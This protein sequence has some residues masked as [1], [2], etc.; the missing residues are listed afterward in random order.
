MMALLLVPLT[1]LLLALLLAGRVTR[2]W[3]LRLA[4]WAALPA[5][6]PVLAAPVEPHFLSWLLL[7]TQIGLDDLS[8][9]FLLFTG[10]V[11]TA[12][13]VSARSYIAR[14]AQVR[15]FTFHLLTLAGNLGLLIA[16]DA[17]TFYLGF[18]LMTFAAY[19]MIVHDGTPAARRAGRVYIIM[20]VMGESALL[21][22]LVMASGAADGALALD[23]ITAAVA[24]SPRRSMI[25]ALLIAGFAV[26]AGALPLHLWLPLAHPVAPTPASAVLSGCMIKAGLLGWL[27]FLPMGEAA[28]PGWGAMLVA[29]GL[30]ATFLGVIAGVAQDDAKTTLAYSSIS[31]MGFMSVA[32]GIGLSTPAAA[33]AAFVACAIY[34]AHHGLAKGALFLGVGVFRA[35]GPARAR[36]AVHAAMLLPALALAGAP[37]TSGVI[38]KS[39][40][41]E[42]AYFATPLPV[43]LS[44]LMTLAAA[45]TAL[46]LIRFLVLVGRGTTTEQDTT[47]PAGLWIPFAALVA[48]TGLFGIA[49]PGP[50]AASDLPHD[51]FSPANLLAATGPLLGGILVAWLGMQLRP[52]VRIPPG[53]LLIPLETLSGWMRGRLALRRL[54]KPAQPITPF[55]ARWYGIYAASSPTDRMLRLEIAV[56]RWEMAALFLIVIVATLFTVVWAGAT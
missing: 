13:G 29:T 15:Y 5:L 42:L 20:A 53:D 2:S 32:V 25:V 22:G 21:A 52:R 27:R 18:A 6:A 3:A 23:E 33:P 10:L 1:P 8:R 17:V 16:L 39:H 36:R 47:P 54:P 55:A 4:P 48:V 7:G 28:L 41:K 35:A 38:A 26:K 14:D 49:G 45:G 43:P 24:A 34:A 19:G 31:Q 37:L 9:A 44:W 30:A 51:R 56:T 11:W 50:F 40:L 46:I 12:A